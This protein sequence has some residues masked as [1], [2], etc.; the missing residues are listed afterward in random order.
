[1]TQMGYKDFKILLLRPMF[2]VRG[3]PDFKILLLQSMFMVRGARRP[4][5]PL[6]LEFQFSPSHQNGVALEIDHI[7]GGC[8]TCYT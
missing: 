6:A 1:M 4:S 8:K 5:L 7:V 2:M 3:G